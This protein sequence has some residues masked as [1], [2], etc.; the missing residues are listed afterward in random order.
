MQYRT[1][2][3]VS[4]RWPYRAVLFFV[5]TCLLPDAAQAHSFEVPYVLPIPLWIYMYACMAMLVISFAAIGYYFA[6]PV[7]VTL[8][9]PSSSRGGVKSG[10]NDYSG[11]VGRSTVLALR[12]GA[13]GLL[14]LTIAAGFIG[15][16]DPMV[17]INMTLFWVVFLLGFA[18]LTAIIGDVFAIISPW[19][20]MLDVGQTCGLDFSKA[21]VIYPRALGYLPALCCYVALIWIE[22]FTEQSPFV[23]SVALVAYSVIVFVGAWLFGRQTWLRYGEFFGVFFRLIG[24]MAPVAY[25]RTPGSSEWHWRS[26]L[27]FSGI[28]DDPKEHF[29]LVLFVLFM[30]SSTIYDGLHDTQVWL[31]IYWKH[32]LQLIEPMWGSVGLKERSTLIIFWHTIYQRSGLILLLALYVGVYLSVIAIAKWIAKIDAS[33]ASLAQRFAF[34][35]I[36]I[37]F[38]YNITHYITFLVTQIRVLPWLI[39]D[40]FGKGWNLLNISRLPDQFGLLDMA[41]VWHM[42]VGLI[43]IGHLVSVCVAHMISLRICHTRRQALLTQVPMLVLMMVYTSVGLWI[44]SLHLSQRINDVGG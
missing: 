22:L 18:Y 32:L 2:L 44:L 27:P 31:D 39:S 13:V 8:P 12:T 4:L 11:A 36:P 28:I 21:R 43:L 7:A 35:L 25:I 6:T 26:R 42:Q 34:S 23:L 17:N 9:A 16:K 37:A 14:L 19:E 3:E 10:V 1:V 30:L 29:S 15:T 38:V 20:A 24:A 40:P 41:F 33:V 5:L